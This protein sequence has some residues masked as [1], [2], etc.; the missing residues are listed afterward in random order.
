MKA[1]LKC[2]QLLNRNITMF[3]FCDLEKAREITDYKGG[4]FSTFSMVPKPVDKHP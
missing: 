4:A 1:P 2:E 3:A